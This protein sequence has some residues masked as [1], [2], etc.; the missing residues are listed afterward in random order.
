MEY[1]EFITTIKVDKLVSPEKFYLCNKLFMTQNNVR[2]FYE[3]SKL[4]KTKEHFIIA[5]I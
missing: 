2:K 1:I 3:I 5:T 4:F